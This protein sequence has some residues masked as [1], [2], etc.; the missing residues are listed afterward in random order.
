MQD[1]HQRTKEGIETARL[2]GKQIGQRPGAKLKIK[3]AA[4][5]KAQI[6]KHSKSFNG[7][8][9]DIECIKLTGISR[10]TYYKYKRELRES[11]P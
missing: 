6:L 2:N 3:K 4:P 1:L 11:I 10:N 9:S 7:T 8:L 5:A